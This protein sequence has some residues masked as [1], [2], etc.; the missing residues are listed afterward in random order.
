[1]QFDDAYLETEPGTV[2][3]ISK[4]YLESFCPALLLV[5]LAGLCLCSFDG[6]K[7]PADSFDGVDSAWELA[8]TNLFRL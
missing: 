5:P 8:E 4:T 3:E 2:I 6:G 7:A 1:M